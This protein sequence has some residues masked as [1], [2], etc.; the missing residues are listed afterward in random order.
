MLTMK[1]ITF[2]LIATFLVPFIAPALTVT[3]SNFISQLGNISNGTDVWMESGTYN[4]SSTDIT[5]LQNAVNGKSDVTFQELSGHTVVLKADNDY[6]QVLEF[7]NCS[8]LLVKNVAL[9]NLKLKYAHCTN[10]TMD[11]ITLERAIFNVTG[12]DKDFGKLQSI[13]AINYGDNVTIKNCY[14]NYTGSININPHCS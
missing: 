5:D 14:I 2:L 12:D 13:V 4:L 8:G 6:Q 10:S 7:S 1:K 11:G 9:D 3:P